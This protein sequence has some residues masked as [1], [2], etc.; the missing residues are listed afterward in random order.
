MGY[1]LPTFER[2]ALEIGAR[3]AD[4]VL[5]Q[6]LL[7]LAGYP[8]QGIDG[9]F[10]PN[11]RAA[12]VA[13][14]RSRA[15]SGTGKL[16][17]ATIAALRVPY[18]A[19][20]KPPPGVPTPATLG[21]AVALIAE[22]ALTLG[23]RE[24]RVNDVPNSGPWVR[25]ACDGRDGRD[26]GIDWYW[27]AG[28]VRHW[29]RVAEAWTGQTCAVATST[30][31][32]TFLNS[33]R[34]LGRLH[35][36][37]EAQRGWLTLKMNPA[38]PEIDAVHIEAVVGATGRALKVIAGNTSGKGEREGLRVAAHEHGFDGYLAVRL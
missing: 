33:A 30:S 19:A 4:V 24:L 9:A 14:Q 20:C 11:T 29:I 22:H 27:C 18:E 16:D 31:C 25:M 15:L 8:P 21:E 13:Y 34:K 3:G 26:G 35:P 37:A 36:A 7:E 10:G 17:A 23:I 2:P 38:K 5:L 1:F 28:E 32:D 12:L 6:E